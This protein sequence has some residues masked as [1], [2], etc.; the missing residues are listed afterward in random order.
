MQSS[1]HFPCECGKSLGV[2]NNRIKLND[3]VNSLIKVQVARGY[4]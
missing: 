1:L 4:L 2:D 3:T